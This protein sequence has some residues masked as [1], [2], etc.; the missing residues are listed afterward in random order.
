ME[1]VATLP[2]STQ[3]A[4]LCREEQRFATSN[5]DVLLRAD[6]RRIVVTFRASGNG[7][8]W[9]GAW[10]YELGSLDTDCLC[11]QYDVRFSDSLCRRARAAVGS[12]VTPAACYMG[13]V[14][15]DPETEVVLHSR[16]E[17]SFVVTRRWLTKQTRKQR[18]R[19]AARAACDLMKGKQ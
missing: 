4:V 5:G 2:D 9:L 3:V 13:Q 6:D 17:G 7:R 14:V 1:I 12:E 16:T 10:R 18:G 11:L 8:L 19:K 15:V